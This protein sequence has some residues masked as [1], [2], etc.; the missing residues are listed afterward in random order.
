MSPNLK[1]IGF[2]CSQVVDS[3]EKGTNHEDEYMI[4]EKELIINKYGLFLLFQVCVSTSRKIG[5]NDY[6]TT[7]KTLYND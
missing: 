5:I 7:T 6:A 2:F 1:E 4:N 3:L